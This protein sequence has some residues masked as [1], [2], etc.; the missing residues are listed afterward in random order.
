MDLDVNNHKVLL[1]GAVAHRT[2]Y[3]QDDWR[4]MDTAPRDGTYV[5]LKCTYGVAPWYC[6]ARWTDEGIAHGPNGKQHPF[7]RDR[8]S[9]RKPEGGGPFSEGHLQWR[10]Y[11]G[12]VESYVDPT[13]G[14]QDSMAYWRGAVA[15]KYGLPPDRFESEVKRNVSKERTPKSGFWS[16]LFGW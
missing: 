1:A 8:P 4:S 7:K 5:E 3:R 12:T 13:D 14:M 6:I 15:A 2:M 9:W 11:K 10:P 16:R